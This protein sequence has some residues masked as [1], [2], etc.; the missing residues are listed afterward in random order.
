MYP[1]CNQH[2]D[3]WPPY[4]PCCDDCPADCTE[5]CPADCTADHKG[6]Q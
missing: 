1:C 6:E 4:E 2:G 3:C 5:D